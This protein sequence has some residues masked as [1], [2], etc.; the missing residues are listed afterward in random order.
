VAQHE[1]LACGEGSDRHFGLKKRC[2]DALAR[3]LPCDVTSVRDSAAFGR[4][5]ERL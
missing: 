4:H 1:K 3:R 2:G 5:L